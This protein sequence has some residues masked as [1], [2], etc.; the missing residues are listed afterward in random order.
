MV[1]PCTLGCNQIA[2]DVRRAC[3]AA[4]N[5]VA[6]PTAVAVRNKNQPAIEVDRRGITGSASRSGVLPVRRISQL[7][8]MTTPRNTATPTAPAISQR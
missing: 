7:P 1:R 3:T 4:K 6:A 5:T 8:A 2:P